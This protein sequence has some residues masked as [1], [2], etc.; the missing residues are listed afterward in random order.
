MP[1]R[2]GWRAARVA[3]IFLIALVAA[4]RLLSAAIDG[5]YVAL[6]RHP[7]IRQ[8]LSEAAQRSSYD[9]LIL[10]SSRTF[11]SVHP[12]HIARDLG[13]TAFKEASKGRSLRYHYEFYREYAR[14]VGTPKLVIF[15]IDYFMFGGESDPRLMRGFGTLPEAPG[16][17]ASAFWPPLRLAA[18]KAEN[19]R[20]LMRILERLQERVAS[21]RGDFDPENNVADMASYT[22]KD[23]SRV[24]VR[25]VPPPFKT[26]PFARHPGSE[27]RYFDRLLDTW[28]HDGVAVVFVYPPDYI[29]THLTDVEHDAFIRHIRELVQGCARCAVLDYGDPARFPLTEAAYFWDGDYGNANSHLSKAGAEAF[30]RLF[31]PDL[32]RE[33]IRLGAWPPVK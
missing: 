14:I 21:G 15:G 18:H 12:A 8:K 17:R 29:A 30:S 7:P 9:W 1:R 6:E 16:T 31:L 11:E 27:G 10:G 3:T 28:R 20:A 5:V 25:T 22:G 4:D 33:A 2:Q 32:K 26:V 19:E 13:V 23:E 24:V